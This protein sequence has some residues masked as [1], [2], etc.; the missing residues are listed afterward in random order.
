MF[1]DDGMAQYSET[2]IPQF[3]RKPRGKPRG[4]LVKSLALADAKPY[5]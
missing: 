1:Q 5:Q 4:L 3:S 2:E